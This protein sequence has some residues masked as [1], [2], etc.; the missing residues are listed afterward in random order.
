MW[1]EDVQI[2]GA[3]YI[4]PNAVQ[5]WRDLGCSGPLPLNSASDNAHF[6]DKCL[7]TELMTHYLRY[8]QPLH[9]SSISMGALEDLGFVVNW[10]EQDE[11]TLANLGDCGTACP[12]AGSVR[13]ALRGPVANEPP[14]L[15]HTAQVELLEA[16]ADRFRERR[17]LTSDRQGAIGDQYSGVQDGRVVSYLYQENG[18]FISH[19]IHQKQVE[20]R[21]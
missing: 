18:H 6:N 3:D 20:S 8:G 11:Y 14:Q 17:A 12:E 10:D 13:R 2:K 4:G 1:K 19:T 5:A 21:M 9:I 16:A 7:E 15:S